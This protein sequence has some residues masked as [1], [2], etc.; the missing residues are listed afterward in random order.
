MFLKRKQRVKLKAKG[1]TECCYHQIFN[2][3]L[4]SSSDLVQPNTHKG[5]CML[6]TTD[7]N[8]KL[9][10]V[11]G[12]EDDFIVMK[13]TCFNKQMFDTILCSWMISRALIDYTDMK[14]VIHRILDKM[15]APSVSMKD[16]IVPFRFDQFSTANAGTIFRYDTARYFK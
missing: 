15:Y 10:S 8:C 1:C 12:R 5:C 14:R 11:L 13:W 6:D 16:S 9:R 3:V 4:K 2:H 7:Y